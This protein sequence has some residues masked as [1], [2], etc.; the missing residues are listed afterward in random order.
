[1]SLPAFIF[2]WCIVSGLAVFLFHALR[3]GGQR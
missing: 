1:M 3:T 2:G